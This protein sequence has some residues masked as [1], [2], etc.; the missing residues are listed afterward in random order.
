MIKTPCPHIHIH[1]AGNIKVNTLNNLRLSSDIVRWD[2]PNENIIRAAKR[3]G[4]INIERL[5]CQD[6]CLVQGIDIAK[7]IASSV[8]NPIDYSINGRVHLH[9]AVISQMIAVG[10]VNGVKFNSKTVLLSHTP[11][12]I[13]GSVIIGKPEQLDTLTPL[14]FNDMRVSFVNDRNFSEFHA[15]LIRRSHRNRISTEIFTDIQMLSSLSVDNLT[16]RFLMNSSHVMP[17][18]NQLQ[19]QLAPIPT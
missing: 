7:W 13:D 6:N 14:T 3:F 8:L 1:F 19:D 15:N 5:Y 16:N 4:A 9:N 18:G 17:S 2:R 11:Q 12:R 10:P